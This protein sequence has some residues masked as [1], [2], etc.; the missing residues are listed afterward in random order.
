MNYRTNKRP[1][2]RKMTGRF[3]AFISVLLVLLVM[4]I[5]FIATRNRPQPQPESQP[6]FDPNAAVETVMPESE[7][8]DEQPVADDFGAGDP[9]DSAPVETVQA[10]S[11]LGVRTGLDQAW[12]NILL[13]GSDARDMSKINQERSDTIM[14]VSVNNQTGQLK[15]TSV[16]RDMEIEIPDRGMQKVNSATKFGGPQLMMQVLNQNLGL[17]ISKYAIVNFQGMA[18]IIDILGGVLVDITK[19][20]AELVNRYMGNIAMYTMSKEAYLAQKESMKL[21]SY[22][23]QKRL[24]GIQAVT[25]MRIRH[26]DGG[27]Q[28]RTQ[29]QKNVMRAMMKGVQGADPVKLMQIGT[30]V[31]SHMETNVG[32]AE[33]VTL[34][35]SVL[36]CGLEEKDR[37]KELRI[38]DATTSKMETRNGVSG[39]Y[40]VDYPALQQQMLQF[41]YG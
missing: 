17:N 1:P 18:E 15:M 20:E 26:L 31:L 14:I 3:F 39:L 7:P 19:D 13:M 36:N 41:I 37:I 29:R 35:L 2:K 16:M 11:D 24:N 10:A 12:T 25:Y 5:V 9:V 4:L 28:Q 30:T 40:D 38:P 22:G 27:D 21:T 34:A 6:V 33:G 8:T 32:V 23:T